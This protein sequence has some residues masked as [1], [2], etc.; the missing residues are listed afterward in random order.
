M[1]TKFFTV[2]LIGL[3]LLTGCSAAA[4]PSNNQSNPSN[5]GGQPPA[6]AEMQN[7]MQ[8]GAGDPMMNMPANGDQ[9]PSGQQP[10]NQP[11]DACRPDLNAAATILNI[12][13]EQ[14]QTALGDA[15]KGRPDLDAAA[16]QLGISAETLQQALQQ[17]FPADCP[18]PGQPGS[19]KN[20]N[21]QG[22]GQQPGNGQGQQPGNDRNACHPDMAKAAT[23]LNITDQQ[24]TD[25]LGDPGQG[26]PD[27]ES[28]ATKLG[29]S[30]ET[31]RNALDGAMPEGCTGGGPKP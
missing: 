18:T 22:Q 4:Q 6:Q 3:L 10:G 27:L 7:P 17:S 13:V 30:L 21:E 25:A 12:S 20:G 19:N 5:G 24:L 28:A 9:P 14:L 31:L 8:T 16:T 11:N 15:S 29:I 23:T 2:L 26:R 1:K